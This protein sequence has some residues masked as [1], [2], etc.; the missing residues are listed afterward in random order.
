[1]VIYFAG[2][3]V[4]P[5]NFPCVIQLQQEQSPGGPHQLRY[6]CTSRSFFFTRTSLHCRRKVFWDRT[7][8]VSVEC[9][10]RMRNDPGIFLFWCELHPSISSGEHHRRNGLL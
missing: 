10:T 6:T 9:F 2:L 3:C 4:V 5:A 1:M 7:W 8:A